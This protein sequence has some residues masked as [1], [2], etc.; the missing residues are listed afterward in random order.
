MITGPARIGHL[1]ANESMFLNRQ[2]QH[3]EPRIYATE[4]PALH[5]RRLVP[6][7][8]E[9]GPGV[10]SIVWRQTDKSGLARIISA[11]AKDLPRVD[12]T[13]SENLQG[14]K[15]L[16]VAFGWNYQELMK[17]LRQQ[18]NLDA[19]RGQVAFEAMELLID[20][21]I[22]YGDEEHNLPGVFSTAA[23]PDTAV[24]ADGAGGGGSQTEWIH[25][26]PDQIIRDVTAT[27]NSIPEATNGLHQAD[28]IA[29]P[30]EQL[31]YLSVTPRSSTSD[32][33]ILQFLK[34]NLPQIKRWEGCY[35]FKAVPQFSNTDIMMA[36]KLD[37]TVLKCHIP[38][39]FKMLPV[40]VQNLEFVINCLADYA[41]VTVYRPMACAIAKAI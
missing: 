41:G 20:L 35:R 29:M 31:G 37:P 16:G 9:A 40:Q 1:D 4:Y 14:V 18:I 25:K 11:A 8:N 38:V 21:L 39:E 36:Y 17:A 12:I 19:E 15:H 7:S 5:G 10:S 32:T 27:V 28:T 22:W 23:I 6:V 33:T 3:V 13:T 30:I 26:T 34:A 24:A 2:L